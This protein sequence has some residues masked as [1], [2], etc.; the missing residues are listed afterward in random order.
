MRTQEPAVRDQFG[1][2]LSGRLI[3]LPED[4]KFFTFETLCG[5]PPVVA[6]YF[7]CVFK[8]GQPHI[9][10]ARISQS[11]IFRAGGWK[12]FTAHQTVTT[13]PPGFVWEAGI[14]MAPLI[15]VRVRDSYLEGNGSIRGKLFGIVPIVN[16]S[17]G[18][19]LSSGALQRYLAEAV[20]FPT[21]LL[22]S[23]RM[24][25]SEI[26]AGKALAKLTD[27]GNE[28]SL[29]FSFNDAGEV[30]RIFTPGRYQYVKGKYE[31]T[32]WLIHLRNYQEFSGIRIPVE[33]EVEW[34]HPEGSFCY[35]KGRI[36]GIEYDFEKT[37]CD[38]CSAGAPSVLL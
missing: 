16:V 7:R 12:P 28:V 33:A 3:K 19:E 8:K 18:Q 20:W 22:P 5:I 21:A 38:T 31:I 17:G 15:K 26:D 11:G 29:E 14:R 27:A 35:Y 1:R 10:R 37:K 25:W 23:D 30:T 32:P 24:Q 36:V 34:V 13:Q 2:I 4:P 9:Q 6:R